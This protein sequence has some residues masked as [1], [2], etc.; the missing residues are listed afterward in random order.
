MGQE[1]YMK[2]TPHVELYPSFSTALFLHFPI[3]MSNFKN[4]QPM[5]S[6]IMKISPSP[7]PIPIQFFLA[8]P[9]F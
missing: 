5:I 3:L 8:F 1:C 9:Y 4:P 2:E 7:V 6:L